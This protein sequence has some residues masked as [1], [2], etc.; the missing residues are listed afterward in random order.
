[1]AGRRHRTKAFSTRQQRQITRV[2]GSAR[3]RGEHERAHEAARALRA[4]APLSAVPHNLN[5]LVHLD[6][7]SAATPRGPLS[8]SALELDEGK[9][10]GE[11]LHWPSSICLDGDAEAARTATRDAAGAER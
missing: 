7:R 1:M 8:R 3:T 4:M 9:R 10:L 11:P 6:E 5:G 2:L